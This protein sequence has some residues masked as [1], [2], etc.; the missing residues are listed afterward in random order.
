MRPDQL[1][2]LQ[3]LSEA[4][5]DRFILEADPAEWPGG[6]K[7]PIDM[8]QQERGDQHWCK[9]LAIGTASV[10]RYT[11]ELQAPRM[12]NRPPEEVDD[13][14]DRKIKDAEQRAARAV[15]RA[16]DNAAKRTFD[17]RVHGKP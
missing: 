9:K 11:L 6:N 2:R 4:L 13:S 5:A 8:T 14:L 7:P 17:Q 1:T 16:L 10:L 3:E 15:K 12:D